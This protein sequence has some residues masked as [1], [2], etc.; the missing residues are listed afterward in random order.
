MTLTSSNTSVATVPAS[1]TVAAG[2]TSA[3][4]T[5]TTLAVSATTSVTISGTYNG[6]QSATLAVNP[7]VVVGCTANLVQ[8]T[9]GDS[10]SATSTVTYQN[11]NAATGDLMLV[12]SRWD[13]PAATASSVSDS[14]GNTYI[15]IGGPINIGGN[16]IVEAW[17][18]KNIQGGQPL[19]VTV[20]Y[21]AKTNSISLVDTFEY[22]GLD[23][24]APLDVFASAIGS[25]TTQ[26]SGPSPTTTVNNETIIG[27]FGYSSYVSPFTAGAGFTQE[28][29]DASS[30]LEDAS[31]STKGSYTAT[32]SSSDPANWGAIVIG[33]KNACQPGV[34]VSSVSLNPAT[35]TGGA[36]ST[37]TVTLSSA[38]PA[39]GVVVTLT[40][41]NTAVATVPASV[42]VAA[43]AT[44]ATFTVTTLAVSGTTSV[45]IS[46]TYSG[47]QSAT[48][49]VNSASPK[50]TLTVTAF[51]AS[52]LYGVANPTFTYVITGFVNGDTQSVVSGA[53]S[54]TTTATT[55]SPDGTYPINVAL[56][57]LS[58][59]GYN[60]AFVNATLTISSISTPAPNIQG[61]WEFVDTSGDTSAQLN[62]MGQSSFSTYLLQTSGSTAVT[63]IVAFTVDEVACDLQSDNNITVANSSIDAAGNVQ[64]TFTIIQVAQPTFQYVYTGVLTLGQ[65]GSPT[66]ITGTYQRSAGGCAQGSLGTGTP[67]GNFT[68][69]YFPDVSGTWDGSFDSPDAGSGPTGV[70]ASFTL[71]T[72]ADKSISGTI[73][74]PSLQSSGKACLAGPVTL[75]PGMPEGLSQADG[76]L[77]ELFGTDS[78]GTRLSVIAVA[79]NPDGS[80]AAVGLDDPADGS[81]GTIND[82]T[83][84]AYTAYYGITGGPCDG[85]GGGDAPFQLV[86]KN[87]APP[88]NHKEPPK[89]KHHHHRRIYHHLEHERKTV[90]D[91]KKPHKL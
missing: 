30:M 24:T 67:D 37:G 66:V 62:M 49:T 61:R 38:A 88:R 46:G 15:P 69:T 28:F 76:A 53:P 64:V 47:T 44:S 65:A 9:A 34:T 21:S 42:T 16:S 40:S 73:D 72:N 20:T 85:L 89:K 54:L 80:D 84:N 18:A 55:T 43:G 13:N 10:G 29:Y 86:K 81:N 35:V 78:A 41:S 63:N 11:S 77:L 90:V 91:D 25:G 6:T 83:N 12:F 60:F 4:F 17:Y 59:P 57:T 7:V 52:R 45:T 48:L 68:A 27:L 74:S 23:T 33:F 5:V 51:N 22:S 2:A 50:G 1:V 26:N 31:V 79:T 56:G 87:S 39:G 75:D 3:T 19:A 70:P 32:A 58:A 14:A 82:G 8:V 71:T 36:S